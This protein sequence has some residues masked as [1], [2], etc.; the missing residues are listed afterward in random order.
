MIF[1]YT[2]K[3]GMVGLV[4]STFGEHGANIVSAAVGAAG[5]APEAVMALTMDA[6]VPPAVVEEIAARD[7]FNA[8]DAVDFDPAM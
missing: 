3:P 4:G 5:D 8:G 6:A 1:R 7:D 2:D